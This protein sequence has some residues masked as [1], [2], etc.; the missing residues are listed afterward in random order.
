FNGVSY[1]TLRGLTISTTSTGSYKRVVYLGGS[2]E[3][4]IIENNTL[5]GS[6]NENSTSNLRAVITNDNGSSNVVNNTIIRHNRINGGSYGIYWQGIS[7]SEYETGNVI[8][9]NIIDGFY[10][11]GIYSYYQDNI[12]VRGNTVRS[13]ALSST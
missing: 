5:N 10:N 9:S 13:A 12:L 4:I 6:Q 8:D 1:V 3:H 11:Y 7:S 2:C